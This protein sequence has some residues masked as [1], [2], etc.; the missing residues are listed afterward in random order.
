MEYWRTLYD[1]IVFDEPFTPDVVQSVT[2]IITPVLHLLNH[3]MV[4]T[5]RAAINRLIQVYDYGI[6]YCGFHSLLSSYLEK[7]KEFPKNVQTAVNSKFIPMDLHF[8]VADD[9]SRLLQ[10]KKNGAK[11]LSTGDA[12]E[13]QSSIFYAQLSKLR[14]L[15]QAIDLLSEKCFIFDSGCVF[16]AIE[17]G[18]SGRLYTHAPNL[19]NFAKSLPFTDLKS[20]R[21]LICT[22]DDH[23]IWSA[24]Y[25]EMELRMTAILSKDDSLFEALESSDVFETIARKLDLVEESRAD[26][27]LFFYGLLYGMGPQRLEEYGFEHKFAKSLWKK[28]TE[29]FPSTDLHYRLPPNLLAFRTSRIQGISSS[30]GNKQ[31][32]YYRLLWK[33]SGSQS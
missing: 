7:R 22:D 14:K 9:P 33:T 1:C 12:T 4:L 17:F 25:C 16:P 8:E 27:K 15:N 29:S 24:D 30:E 13:N 20:P 6:P 31:R 19:Q 23:E 2:S 18:S 3:E 21:S 28:F 10:Y 5:V 11:L 32:H 26:V